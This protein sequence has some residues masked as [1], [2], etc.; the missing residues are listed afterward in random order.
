[1][2]IP[3]DDHTSS[4][5]LDIESHYFEFIPVS[6]ADSSSPEVLEAHE[7]EEGGEYLILLT[8]ASGLYRYNIRDVV[9]CTG[10]HGTTPLLEF[11]HKGAHI[12]SITGEKIA[13]SQVVEAVR[14]ACAEVQM[15]LRQYTLTPSWGDP[16]GYTLFVR[17]AGTTNGNAPLDLLAQK[18]DQR[19]QQGNCEY[20][21]KRGTERLSAMTVKVLSAETWQDFAENRMN[22][23]GG[24]VEQ[25]KHPCLLPD[26]QF[27]H[28]F[29]KQCGVEQHRNGRNA[30]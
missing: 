1:M 22:A 5:I 30:S 14:G 21:E 15:D 19:L 3:I 26:P 23:S 7:L 17:P 16:P 4:G 6:E 2:T 13:E 27:E 25:Y 9:R 10:F 12:S 11:R 8:T 18:A 29:L 28:L 24:S 20:L